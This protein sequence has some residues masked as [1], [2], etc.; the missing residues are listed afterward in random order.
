VPITE[1]TNRI[2]K[3]LVALRLLYRGGLRSEDA[4]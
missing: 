2:T 3:V 1:T 4:A